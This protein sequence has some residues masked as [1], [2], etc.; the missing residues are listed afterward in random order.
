MSAVAIGTTAVLL[1]VLSSVVVLVAGLDAAVTAVQSRVNVVAYLKDGT[2]DQARLAL[3]QRLQAEPAVA[4]VSYVSKD[5][6]MAQLRRQFAGHPELLGAIDGNPLPASVGVTLHDPKQARNIGSALRGDPSVSE[7]T[8]N[9]DMVDRLVEASRFIRFCGLAIVTG[10][11]VAVVFVMINVARVAIYARRHEIEVM[12]LVGASR[13]FVRWPFV[14]EGMVCG[15]LAAVLALAVV[16]AG[17]HS[18]LDALRGSLTFLPVRVDP[19]LLP[20]LLAS[21]AALGIGI[22]GSGSLLAVHRFWER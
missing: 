17:Y 7:V 11:G 22:G 10:L 4:T 13:W 15:L 16:G 5:A 8:V 3:V 20:K 2:S 21:A 14:L 1:L 9:Q 18:L 6:A 19:N 12:Q